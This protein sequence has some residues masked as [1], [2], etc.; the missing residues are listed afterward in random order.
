[1]KLGNKEFELTFKMRQIKQVQEEMGIA[2]F[3]DIPAV[4]KEISEDVIKLADFC[5]ACIFYGSNGTFESIEEIEKLI[6]SS[7]EIAPAAPLFIQ[8][9]NTF[10]GIKGTGEVEAPSDGNS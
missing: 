8:A 6:T 5:V 3:K 9:F 7:E 4:F 2:E 1:M 10:Y